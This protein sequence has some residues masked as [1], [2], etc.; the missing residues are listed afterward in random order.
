MTQTVIDILLVEDNPGDVLLTKR[1][2]R[3]S[4]WTPRIHVVSDGEAA[5]EFLNR[6]GEHSDAPRPAL[7]LLDLNLPKLDGQDVLRAIKTSPALRSIPVVMMSSSAQEADVAT[8]YDNHANSYLTKRT[9]V[10]SLTQALRELEH[11]WFSLVR[12]PSPAP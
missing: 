1:A 3:G 11:Y 4:P 8:S 2:L 10:A 7:V 12:R 6:R 9:D 5:L